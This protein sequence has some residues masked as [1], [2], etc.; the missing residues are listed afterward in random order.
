MP[1]RIE[2][3]EKEN[4]Y[5]D[6]FLLHENLIW[7]LLQEPEVPSILRSDA[8]VLVAHLPPSREPLASIG[9]QFFTLCIETQKGAEE[10]HKTFVELLSVICAPLSLGVIRGLR[11]DTAWFHPFF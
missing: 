7:I 5:G 8:L 2:P 4:G 11:V 6:Y 1:R 9:C 3:G 10:H